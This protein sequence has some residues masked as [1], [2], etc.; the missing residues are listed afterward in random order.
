MW[1][2]KLILSNKAMIVECRL[3]V[4]KSWCFKVWG[5]WAHMGIIPRD[6]PVIRAWLEPNYDVIMT[7]YPVLTAE[8]RTTD[9]LCRNLNIFTLDRDWQLEQF[10][11]VPFICRLK[12][13]CWCYKPSTLEL[14]MVHRFLRSWRRSF[15]GWKR[16]RAALPHF[17]RDG[18]G[19]DSFFC[20]FSWSYVLI[21]SWMWKY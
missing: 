15:S 7:N 20:L 17:D 8:L 11:T 1:V 9:W 18:K 2:D 12:P 4:M 14:Q 5:H 6:K 16:P 3:R 19:G 10:I 13:W 21:V